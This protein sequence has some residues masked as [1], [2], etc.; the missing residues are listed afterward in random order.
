VTIWNREPSNYDQRLKENGN[1]MHEV[2]QKRANGF[3]LS[4]VLGNVWEWV[5][6]WYDDK[7]YQNGPSQN[8]PG[9]TSGRYRVLRGGSW[10]NLPRFVR[11]SIRAGFSPDVRN[12]S[13]G[14]R[15]RREAE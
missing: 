12:L 10:F 2:G 11:V 5:N 13:Y 3:G 14:F 8:P 7:Y 6:D 1:A 4:D 9:P 15:C